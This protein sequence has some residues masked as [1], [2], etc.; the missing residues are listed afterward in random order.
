MFW[1]LIVVLGVVGYAWFKV[2]R[3]RKAASGTPAQ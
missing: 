3:G 2:R 1:L